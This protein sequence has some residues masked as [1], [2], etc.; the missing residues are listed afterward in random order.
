MSLSSLN[1]RSIYAITGFT[2]LFWVLQCYGEASLSDQYRRPPAEWPAFIVD[3]Q[4]EAIDI[5]EPASLPAVDWH[6]DE[7][8]NLGKTLF[9]DPRLSK[10][11]QFA[12]ASCHHPSLGWTD[13][14]R[15]SAG[16]GRQEGNRNS[17]TLINVAFFDELFWD[18]RAAGLVDL[19]LKPI[20]SPVE[21]N[22]DIDEVL[23]RL[24]RSPGYRALFEEAFDDPEATPQ[25]LAT[26]LAS[27][28]RTRISRLSDF[29]LF[30]RGN[31]SQL[32]DLQIEGLHLFR[33]KARCM[34]C[35]HGPV[36]SD[37]LF[38]HTGLSYFDRR[39]EDLGRFEHTEEYDDRGKFRTPT[40][41]DLS[42][43]GPW[44]HNGL[45]TNFTGIL[46][47]Y[48]HG[49]TINSRVQKKPGAPPVSPLIQEL[50]MTP[51]EIK[52]LE[53]FLM[54]LNRIPEFVETPDLPDYDPLATNTTKSLANP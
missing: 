5:H 47:A 25:R 13:G 33:T 12:C 46:R 14:R 7:T 45:F 8:E 9:F 42:F 38:H 52:A 20:Q 41:R 17:M 32:S 23:D 43:T 10:S 44:M 51:D 28:V 11:M 37:G 40:L 3:E 31:Y 29:D 6:T 30:I 54:S 22:A 35:H 27:F 53:A 2:S 39:F 15:F 24:N 19:M 26:A 1:R 48:N 21:M 34:N 16:H 4:V 50:H 36:F 49:M 18:G